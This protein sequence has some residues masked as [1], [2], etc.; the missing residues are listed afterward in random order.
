MLEIEPYTVIEEVSTSETIARSVR[1]P[2]EDIAFGGMYGK[3][4]IELTSGNGCIK[5]LCIN[6]LENTIEEFTVPHITFDET[7]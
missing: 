1:L 5:V 6:T 4:F 7:A 3:R 2:F